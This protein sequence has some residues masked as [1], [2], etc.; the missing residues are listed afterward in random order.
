MPGK[1]WRTA[2]ICARDTFDFYLNQNHSFEAT[3]LAQSQ[4]TSTRRGMSFIPAVAPNASKRVSFIGS[5]S[6]SSSSP[7]VKSEADSFTDAYHPEPEKDEYSGQDKSV[8]RALRCR[9]KKCKSL[10]TLI[11]THARAST[12]VQCVPP[13]GVVGQCQPKTSG[14]LAGAGKKQGLH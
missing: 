1:S 9:Q 2:F 13:A 14:Q 8:R 11:C 4:S 12:G 6:Q 5:L 10:F 3:K 7:L